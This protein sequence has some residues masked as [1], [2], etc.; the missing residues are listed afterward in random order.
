MANTLDSP[1]V[2]A[3]LDRL[4]EAADHD[5]EVRAGVSW[6][7]FRDASAQERADLARDVYMPVSREGG[8]LLYSLVRAAQ[9]AVVVEFGMSHGISTI[10]LAAAVADVGAGRVFTTEMSSVKAEAAQRNLAEAGLADVVTVLLGDAQD[11]LLDVPAPVGVALLDGW[12]DLCLPVLKLLE[13]KLAPGALVVADDSHF[14]SMAEYLS[15]VR[16][17]GSPYVNTAFPVEDGMELSCW[18][19]T[20]D[21]A[22]RPRAE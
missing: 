13:P 20:A 11:T 22:A 1:Q 7:Q 10:H 6:D 19:G 2:R 5:D 3:V 16:A 4:F 21:P 18:T 17:P 9:P 8:R 12:K 15:Y 14:A